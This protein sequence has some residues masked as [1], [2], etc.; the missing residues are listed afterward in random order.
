MVRLI[1]AAIWYNFGRK[2]FTKGGYE[3]NSA[4]FDPRAIPSS[5]SGRVYVV[6]GA[7]S[8]I[9][10]MT[11][12]ALVSRGAEVH[13]LCRSR[14][15]AEQAR[16]DIAA[17]CAS[18][19]GKPIGTHGCAGPTTTSDAAVPAGDDGSSG[20]GAASSSSGSSGPS[21]SGSSSSSSSSSSGSSS[22]LASSPSSLSSGDPDVHDRVLDGL[23]IHIVDMSDLSSVRRFASDAVRSIPV[24]DAVVNNAG[25][26]KDKREETGDGHDYNFATNVL[27]PALL[28][29]L[30]MPQLAS[31]EPKGRVVMVSSGGMLT[32]TL[33]AADPQLK[34]WSSYDG[35]RAYAQ[36]KRAQVYLTAYWAKA[37]GDG[38]ARIDGG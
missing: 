8:G 26:M 7:N 4:K 22:G 24:I 14:E 6:T 1:R 17:M 3:A 32:E 23:H 31:A 10:M 33:D 25:V 16:E 38:A 18:A 20:S 11:T 36:N 2:R 34:K 13:M 21:S 27:G 29:E 9:G 12:A 19:R 30:L 15:R 35:T 37:Y 28:T 5:L